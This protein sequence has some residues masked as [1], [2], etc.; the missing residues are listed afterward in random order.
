MLDCNEKKRWSYDSGRKKC[1]QGYSGAY[2]ETWLSLHLSGVWSLASDAVK[3]F[4]HL[5]YFIIEFYKFS[6]FEVICKTYAVINCIT[7]QHKNGSFP[8]TLTGHTALGK[9]K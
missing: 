3:I 5:I 9:V 2:S 7:G 4:W 1:K 8:L 6:I